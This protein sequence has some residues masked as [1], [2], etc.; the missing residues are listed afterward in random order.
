ML[1]V[2]GCVVERN[3]SCSRDVF[4]LQRTHLLLALARVLLQKSNSHPGN[5][6]F[7]DI[8]ALHRPD[9]IRAIKMDKPGVARKIV[10]AIRL[11]NPPG[12]FLKKA[13]DGMYYDV[14]D[15]T[16]AE[17]TSQGLRER[18]NAEKRQRSAL[19][20]ALRIRKQDMV[21]DDA[22]DGATPSKKAKTGEGGTEVSAA[23]PTSTAPPTLNYVGTNLPVPL[24][25]NMKDVSVNKVT[26]TRKKNKD[27]KVVPEELNT[28]GLPPN[29][30]DE[31][32]NIL[33][34]DYDILCGRGGLTN[35]HKG[36]KRFRD[37]VA[38]HRPDYVRAP[39]IQKPSVARVIVRA[40]RNGDPP[41]RFLTKDEKTGKWIDIGDKKAAE[42]T[43]QALREKTNEERDKVKTA[44]AGSLGV[45][46]LL[47]SPAS[48]LGTFP[49]ILP[50]LPTTTTTTPLP[51]IA[52]P[53]EAVAA[54]AEGAAK[55][56]SGEEKAEEGKPDSDE[57]DESKADAA[58]AE[59]QVESV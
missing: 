13:D 25:L 48:Y 54:A 46:V 50:V 22:E 37:I 42:K 10:K 16:A 27:G 14:G 15:R 7:R 36:N 40:I 58:D 51:T 57:K 55:T 49:E 53:G 47:P 45:G 38:L 17:K 56:D 3:C 4:C 29:A 59:A 21:E 32:G 20:E 2:Y 31:E 43:S 9:Y 11:G 24:S 35:H 26:V 6:R 12:R 34:T 41:G 39:K 5:R 28:E 44:P 33:V 30:V 1:P 18:T 52:A 8:I 19:R 23:A